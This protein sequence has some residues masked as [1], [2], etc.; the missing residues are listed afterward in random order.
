MLKAGIPLAGGS[1]C[2]VEPPD[3]LWGIYAAVTRKDMDGNPKG[4][5]YP[6]ERVTLDEAIRMFTEG[7]AY[8]AF[9]EDQKGTL[10]SGK[11]ADF[12]VLSEDIYKIAPDDL[13][14]V[15]VLMTVVG[16]EIAYQKA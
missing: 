1:D 4:A 2:P 10:E 5:F 7:G 3:P 14:D 13:K 15:K 11:L 16:G 6:N 12:V 8:A 9:Q